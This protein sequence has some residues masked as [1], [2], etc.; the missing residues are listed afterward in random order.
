MKRVV[1]VLMM[2]GLTCIP[3]ICAWAGGGGHPIMPANND[4]AWE[5]LPPVYFCGEAVPLHEETVARRL[6]SAL[7]RNASYTKELGNIRQ[8]A[9]TFFPLI[10]PIMA[11][12]K[13]P[14]DFRYL[15]LVESA[16]RGRAVSRAGAM[17]YWQL[18]PET[19]R[20]LGLTVEYN[21]DERQHLLKSTDAACRYLR[22]LYH[23]LGSWTLAAAAYNN[24]IGNLLASIRKQGE[25]DYYYLHLNAE[26]GRYLYRILAF[27][28]L[29]DNYHSY[30]TMLSP[31]VWLVLSKPV[32][33]AK[34]EADPEEPLL[35]ESLIVS[36]TQKALD[37]PDSPEPV[38]TKRP[39]EMPLP[40]AGDVFEG[41]IKARLNRAGI[42]ERGQVWVFHLTRDGLA[43]GRQVDQGDVLY[44]IVEDIDNQTGKVYL[45]ADR[46][47]SASDRQ[48][49]KLA[50]SAV[51]ASTGRLG[52]NIADMGQVKAGWI[53]V[54]KVI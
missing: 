2:V 1:S 39:S 37:E 25:R 26:T 43:D 20:E 50:L 18:M 53:S 22:F 33:P 30:R 16:L 40:N 35:S 5:D 11:R 44:A 19:A 36:A 24:G 38:D 8:R 14:A 52:I 3:V 7:V 32:T 47:Y 21:Y 13:I 4:P 9:S 17:G 42:L 41:G 54:W 51:D 29:F 49:H 48:T 31:D 6:M 28:E 15:P 10:E 45:R 46:V 23:K 27:K 12:Y 34:L